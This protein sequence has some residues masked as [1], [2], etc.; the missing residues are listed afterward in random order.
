MMASLDICDFVSSA[1][2]SRWLCW[3]DAVLLLLCFLSHWYIV[4]LSFFGLKSFSIFRLPWNLRL[5]GT[6]RPPCGRSFECCLLPVII[7]LILL[8]SRERLRPAEIFVVCGLQ[9][10]AICSHLSHY[11]FLL[12]MDLLLFVSLQW[13]SRS[14]LNKWH[15]YFF[16]CIISTNTT[17]YF[18]IFHLCISFTYVTNIKHPIFSNAAYSLLSLNI[19]TASISSYTV[20]MSLLQ[21]IIQ[22][23]KAV[24]ALFSHS[25]Q[26]NSVA[27]A[28][29]LYFISDYQC[30][31]CVPSN[32]SHQ[33]LL[34]I[35]AMLV[36]FELLL[37]LSGN[38]SSS[39]IAISIVYGWPFRVSATFALIKGDTTYPVLCKAAIKLMVIFTVRDSSFG[40]VE[41][42]VIKRLKSAIAWYTCAVSVL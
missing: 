30:S 11:L 36:L 7:H 14:L 28:T 9:W 4:Q 10:Q 13:H 40:C 37:A 34:C 16:K 20:Y 31:W 21:L 38:I 17:A 27:G 18:K 42:S 25:M 39:S 32:H 15:P 12:H 35:M 1:N 8:L 29:T 23:A 24:F 3:T 33:L 5:H 19:I 2:C 26:Q 41:H 22:C 6:S